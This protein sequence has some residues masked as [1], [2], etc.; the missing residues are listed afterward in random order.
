MSLTRCAHGREGHADSRQS[1][2]EIPGGPW[3]DANGRYR[4]G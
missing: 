4:S 1:R 2:T 3:N